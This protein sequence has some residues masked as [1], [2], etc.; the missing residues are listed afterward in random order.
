MNG[1]VTKIRTELTQA[2]DQLFD[3][4]TIREDVLYYQPINDG[5]SIHQVL[6]HLLLA[7]YFLLRIANKQVD[8]A[9]QLATVTDVNKAKEYRLDVVTLNRMGLTGSYI[10]V[11]QRFTEPAGEMPLLELKMVLHDQL[12][13]SLSLL[14]NETALKAII[15]TQEP[16][17]IDALHY[18]Y[19]L[20][21]HIQRHLDQ[22][23]RVKKE[24]YQLQ[25]QSTYLDNVQINDDSFCLN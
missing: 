17:R 2:F 9:F 21:Q 10:W 8:R 13:R 22:I 6:E 1:I 16:G 15:N 23:A 20:A 19:F 3:V 14:K 12:S 5:W 7:N 11:P 25:R 4:F 18:L 24:F